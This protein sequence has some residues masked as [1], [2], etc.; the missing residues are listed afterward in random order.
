MSPQGASRGD[1]L[2]RKYQP[3]S[4]PFFDQAST[5]MPPTM[6]A[7]FGFCRYFFLTHGVIHAVTMKAAEYAITDIIF[8]HKYKHVV[9]R[10]EELMLGSMNYRV[11]EFEANLDYYVYGN[12]MLSPSFPFKKFLKCPNCPAKV[13]ALES[14]ANWRYTNSKFWFS[15]P[16]CG[17]TGYAKSFDEQITRYNDI[18]VVRWNPELVSILNNETTGHSD[19]ILDLSAEFKGHVA[20]GR[21][22]L[23]ATTPEI[24][25]DALRQKRGIVFDPKSVFHMRRPALSSMNK[26]WGIPLIMPVLKDAYYMQVLKKA[27]EAV[28]LT[29]IVP[30]IFLFP[31]PATGGADPFVTANLQQWRDHLRREIS[32]QRMDPSYYGILPFPV[33]HQTIGENGKNLLLMP[34]IRELAEQM[35]V[36]MGFPIDLIF[37]NGTYAASSVNMRMLENFFLSNVQARAR[38]LTW[39]TQRV[40]A[41]LNWDLPV[42]KYKPFRMADDLQRQAFN[43]QLNQSGKITD[44]TLLAGMDIKVEDEAE[45]R[46]AELRILR[47]GVTKQQLLQADIQGQ[48]LLMQ[49]KYQQKSQELMVAAAAPKPPDIFSSLQNSSLGGGQPQVTLDAVSA[50]LATYVQSLPREQQTIYMS[51]IAAQAP[52]L[53]PM[54]QQQMQNPEGAPNAPVDMSPTGVTQP[55]AQQSQVDMRPMPQQLPPRRQGM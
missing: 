28:M 41:F 50:A 55:G 40:G 7:L 8:Q 6:K 35:V 2:G 19:Y 9:Q 5:Y 37:G 45:I 29:Y 16:K 31:Q 33:G 20:A 12:A 53:A 11:V 46:L 3:F 39:F 17:Q 25:L 54:V 47:E 30:Q 15:C 22:D 43:L 1:V 38:M 10:W 13:G 34:E 44:T 23:I 42:T 21:K 36:A 49:S 51:Q 24:F 26:G 27:Q 32:R 52:E 4:N 48:M 14:R 18:G